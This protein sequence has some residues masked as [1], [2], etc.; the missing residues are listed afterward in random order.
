[1]AARG[2]GDETRVQE[3]GVQDYIRGVLSDGDDAT[4]KD[5]RQF[6][7]RKDVAHYFLGELRRGFLRPYDNKIH[8]DYDGF[9]NESEAVSLH[10]RMRIGDS[11]YSH[12]QV[13]DLL[14]EAMEMPATPHHSFEANALRMCLYSDHVPKVM[15]WCA[16]DKLFALERRVRELTPL[17]EV[18]S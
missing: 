12:A 15:F 3:Q 2:I 11:W 7:S 6:A 14:R 18:P 4:R 17:G 1:M 5:V 16:T 9:T 10:Y 13:R 8:D